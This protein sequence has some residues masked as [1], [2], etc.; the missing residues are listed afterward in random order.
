MGV[1]WGVHCAEAKDGN[2]PPATAW[3]SDYCH[4]NGL[5]YGESKRHRSLLIYEGFSFTVKNIQSA[6]FWVVGDSVVDRG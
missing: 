4:V 6:N 2:V 1:M 3:E 5:R